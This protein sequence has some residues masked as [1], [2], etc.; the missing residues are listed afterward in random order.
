M[1]LRMLRV[2]TSKSHSLDS[3]N[4]FPASPSPRVPL[5]A[6]PWSSSRLALVAILATTIST[7]PSQEAG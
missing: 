7:L 5:P 2:S 6:R 1:V 3:A 4:F